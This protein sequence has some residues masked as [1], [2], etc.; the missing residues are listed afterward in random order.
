MF[1]SSVRGTSDQ[2]RNN[3]KIRCDGRSHRVPFGTLSCKYTA[4]NIIEGETIQ[5]PQLSEGAPMRPMSGK[6]EYWTREV[7]PDGQEMTIFSYK[8]AARIKLE[9]IFILDRV[10]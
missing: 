3:Y 2:G 5:W 8:D 7:S 10:K 4:P 9:S 6:P 1:S